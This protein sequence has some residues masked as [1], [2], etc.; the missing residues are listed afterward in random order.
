M[1]IVNLIENTEG[2]SKCLFEHG[3]SFYIETESHKALLDLGQ[4][5]SSLRNAKKLGINLNEVD[6]VVLSHGHYDHSG[7]IIPF[8]M[9]NDHAA[10]YMQS[11]AG[12]DFYANDGSNRYRYIGIDKEILML[13]QLRLLKGDYVIDDELELFTIKNRT[14]PLPFTNKRLLIKTACGFVP[15][16]FCHEHFLVVK[17][18]EH[19]ILMSGCAHNGIL[20]ILDTYREK[21]GNLPDIVISGFHLM[22]KRNYRDSELQEVRFIAKELKKYQIKFY[23]CHCT[24]IPAFEE[25]K[26]IMGNQLKYIHSGEQIIL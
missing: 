24:G 26:K 18:R 1:R 9:I 6:T 12:G 13:P 10:I 15:D 21:Y 17:D 7:G 14:H 20:S 16:D 2:K 4:T 25:M 3:L 19:T 11:L 23:T 22:V 8:T 5:D